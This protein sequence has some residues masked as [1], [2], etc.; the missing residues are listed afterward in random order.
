MF[1]TGEVNRK[2]EFAADGDETAGN[3]I[4]LEQDCL[5]SHTDSV[6]FVAHD[7][8]AFC[9]V[10]IDSLDDHRVVVRTG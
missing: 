3:V 1:S 9:K 5:E 2:C 6:A 7:F 8:E 4:K 10:A